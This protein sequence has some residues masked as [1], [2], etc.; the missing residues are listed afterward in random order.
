MTPIAQAVQPMKAQAQDWAE[1]AIRAR[2]AMIMARLEECGMDSKQAFPYPSSRL[3]R[4]EYKKARALY[5][6]CQ[7]IT[8]WT[9]STLRPS[10]PNIRKP[11]PAAIERK[12]AQWREMAA[13]SFEAFV[14]KLEAKVGEHDACTMDVEGTWSYSILR[15]TK[16]E[17]VERWKTQMIINCSGLGTLYNQ[18]PTRKLKD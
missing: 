15:V 9:K 4:K 8:T 1:Q 17:Q 2:C 16:G 14:A 3:S 18:W 10:E 7:G 12:V 5:D 13:A 6:L 11:V